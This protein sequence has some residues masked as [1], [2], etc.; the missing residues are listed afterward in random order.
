MVQRGMTS[1]TTRH[2]K[3][4]IFEFGSDPAIEIEKQNSW[5]HYLVSCP[6]FHVFLWYIGGTNR[7]LFWTPVNTNLYGWTLELLHRPKQ[8]N[9]AVNEM[10]TFHVV[11]M[12]PGLPSRL[13]KRR[14]LSTEGVL[15]T[16]PLNPPLCSPKRVVISRKFRWPTSHQKVIDQTITDKTTNPRF[17]SD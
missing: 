14:V 13:A 11:H 7:R 15:S 8:T 16:R 5:F 17:L 1:V 3:Q 4:L 6:F 9:Y 10:R 12:F 2:F